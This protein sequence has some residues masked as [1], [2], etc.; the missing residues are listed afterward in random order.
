MRY[1]ELITEVASG[2][3]SQKATDELRDVIEKLIARAT[4]EGSAKGSLTVTLNFT[5]QRDGA[6]EVFP[7]I[8][9]KSPKASIAKGAAWLSPKGELL[10]T[11]P[12]QG[13]L[14]LKDA[15]AA[16]NVVDLPGKKAGG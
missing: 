5:V 11:D 1:E 2:D 13:K 14:K 12:R 16:N 6:F 8:T 15:P 3:V 4:E 9:S 7:K 10:F